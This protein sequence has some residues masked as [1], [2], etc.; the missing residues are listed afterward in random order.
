VVIQALLAK[1]AQ[2]Y[3]V[4]WGLTWQSLDENE[5]I[6]PIYYPES[7][8]I[9]FDLNPFRKRVKTLSGCITD[10]SWYLERIVPALEQTGSPITS[11]EFR[12][13]Y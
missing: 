1:E 6:M 10:L 5:I 8:T 2:N 3:I 7:R 13:R 11:I 4:G 12:E 9:D